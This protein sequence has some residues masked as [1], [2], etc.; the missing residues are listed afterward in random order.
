VCAL[1]F[2]FALVLSSRPADFKYDIDKLMTFIDTASTAMTTYFRVRRELFELYCKA[3]DPNGTVAFSDED[4]MV[5][6]QYLIARNSNI[7]TELGLSF[8]KTLLKMS[9]E[10]K[11]HR[12]ATAAGTS[13]SPTPYTPTRSRV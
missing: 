12:S 5:I 13:A 4:H 11:R 2:R 9:R 7:P 3:L 6:R 8:E 1:L 10:I